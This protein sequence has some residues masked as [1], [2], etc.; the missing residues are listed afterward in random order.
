M[1]LIFFAKN[2]DFPM[3]NQNNK[4][5]YALSSKNSTRYCG[6]GNYEDQ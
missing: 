6:K 4:R 1:Q 2:L 3:Q 5:C